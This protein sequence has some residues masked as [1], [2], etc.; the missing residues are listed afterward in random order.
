MILAKRIKPR[1]LPKI[2]RN[3]KLRAEVFERDGGVCAKCG[4]YD[5]HWIHDHIH[6]LWASG[7][8]TLENSQTLCRHC[9]QDKTS[10]N[11]TARAKT[12]RLRERHDATVRRRQIQRSAS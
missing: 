8:D 10:E 11:T 12:D 1:I 3:K 9:N 2:V 6:E 7:P 4:R 5:S